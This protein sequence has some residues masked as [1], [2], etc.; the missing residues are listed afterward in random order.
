M[1]VLLVFC[2][3]LGCPFTVFSQ[4]TAQPVP[5]KWL[6]EG[7]LIPEGFNFSIDSPDPD[8]EW[9]YAYLPDYQGSNG[10]TEEPIAN[11]AAGNLETIRPEMDLLLG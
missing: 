4:I 7:K 3:L 9:S 2:T 6:R 10:H 5:S 1:L 11:A 8:S